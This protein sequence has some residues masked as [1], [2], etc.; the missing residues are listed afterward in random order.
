MKANRTPLVFVGNI[1][2]KPAATYIFNRYGFRTVLRVACLALAASIC[3]TAF[4]RR[5][6]PVAVIIVISGISGAASAMSPP[7]RRARLSP[8]TPASP[9]PMPRPRTPRTST[10]APQLQKRV[11][12]ATSPDLTAIDDDPLSLEAALTLFESGIGI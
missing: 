8:T 12:R 6:T 4:V 5:Q 3:A 7:P 1:G 9:A 10:E 11:Q 2:V